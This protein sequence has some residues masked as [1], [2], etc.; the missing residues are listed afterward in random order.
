MC[1]ALQ[2]E[3][4]LHRRIP[5]TK[6]SRSRSSEQTSK[7]SNQTIPISSKKEQTT[8]VE[9][10]V[11]SGTSLTTSNTSGYHNVWPNWID[12]TAV[13]SSAT[14][15]STASNIVW[16]SW[17][18]TGVSSVT[19]GGTFSSADVTWDTWNDKVTLKTTYSR[20]AWA[21]DN[22]QAQEHMQRMIA[23]QQRQENEWQERQRQVQ[24]K[25]VVAKK[26]A[27]KLLVEHLNEVQRQSLEKLGYFDVQVQ[28]RTFR[29][30]ANRYSQNVIEMDD[31]GDRIAQFCAHLTHS[32][33]LEDHI[34]AQKLVLE[35]CPEEF[36]KVANRQ[37]LRPRV[38]APGMTV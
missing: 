35:G 24:E 10:S 7:L 33:P 21:L 29:I 25:Q 37:D 30:H 12:S 8:N 9:L 2:Q 11:V 1:P 38:H 23:D 20:D 22:A 26:R 28:G 4:P 6:R 13:S 14:M 36:F 32:C 16:H 5:S 18:V 17:T 3:I 31:K 19:I 34:L 27:K 15:S